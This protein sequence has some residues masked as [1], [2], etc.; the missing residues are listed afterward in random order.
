MLRRAERV[1]VL[2]L[3]R[4]LWRLVCEWVAA[5]DTI[6][7]EIVGDVTSH[8]SDSYQREQVAYGYCNGPRKPCLKQ[9]RVVVNGLPI[10]V[11]VFP[12]HI[13]P[14][15]PFDQALA[16]ARLFC[17]D[18]RSRI[19][20]VSFDSG[21]ASEAHRRRLIA[22]ARRYR[23]FRFTFSVAIPNPHSVAAAVVAQAKAKP[24]KTWRRANARTRVVEMN[25]RHLYEDSDSKTRVIVVEST[26]K[27]R[28]QPPPKRKRQKPSR[29][30][31]RYYL[32]ATNHSQSERKAKHVFKRH[33]R[34]AGVEFSIK[35]SKQSYDLDHLPHERFEANQMF[36]LIATLAQ[37]LG[38]LYNQQV[39]PKKPAGSLIVPVRTDLWCRPGQ[40][41]NATHIV[42]APVYRRLT[43]V[44]RMCRAIGL[45]F[46]I[47][48]VMMGF[49][50]S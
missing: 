5:A 10:Y 12:G 4:L 42:I 34:R 16:L 22:L 20:H 28:P 35:D 8:P 40:V 15:T 49:D 26:E 48:I 3:R 44:R 46:G 36:L 31:I 17:R 13:N 25:W 9:G 1:P 32:I 50:S 43:L 18:Y 45:H 41:I 14:Q 11:A 33:H 7:I 30:P 21:F 37:V 24:R 6:E 23:N 19:I 27:S 29:A 39:L 47:S 2:Q 38:V